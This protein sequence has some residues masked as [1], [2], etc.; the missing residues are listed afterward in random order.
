MPRLLRAL[1]DAEDFYF[2]AISQIRM[3]TWSRG[4][5]TLVGDAGY[6]PGPAV[7][8]GTSL[9][10][11]GAHLLAAT[12]AEAGRDPAAGFAAYERAMAEPVRQSRRVGPAVLRTLVPG[13]RAQVWLT[14]RVLQT[15]TS[16]PGPLR[17][18]LTAYG[19][20]PARMLGA[21][22]LPDDDRLPTVP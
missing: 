22:V 6:C 16:L 8:G 15:L 7:G 1:P 11:V 2:D 13:S 9:A 3:G 17:R 21:V 19:G 10:V 18:R 5:V 20:G 12:V 14:P 4:R